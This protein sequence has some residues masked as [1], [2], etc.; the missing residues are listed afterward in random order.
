MT[1][2]LERKLC[3]AEYAVG[4]INSGL[5]LASGGFVGAAHPE[6]LTAELE[7]RF[8]RDGSPRD[9]TLVYA[10][11]QGD[12]KSRG[13]NHLGHP[14]LIK[15]V[16]G[17]HW[18]LA[19]RMG[20]MA[21][22][23]QTQAYNIPQGVICQ[24]FREIGAGRPGVITRVGMGTFI[25]PA[26]Q[27]GRLNDV[28]PDAVV[29]SITLNGEPWL[30]YPSFPVHVG[31]IR[32]SAADPW[33]NLIMDRE[34]VVGDVLQIAQ[35]VKN[36]ASRITG[37]IPNPPSKGLLIAQVQRLL[38]APAPPQAVRVPGVL[39]DHI[40]LAH[41]GEHDQTFAEAYN[42][43]YCEPGPIE[44]V[45]GQSSH[46]PEPMPDDERR[47]IA[48]RAL[49][50]VPTD[51]IANLGIGMP[52]GIA[53][54]AAE[55]GRL[56]RITLTVESGPIGGAP[57]GGLS[58]GASAHPH[59]IVDPATQF[60]FYDGGG[61]DF[62]ALGLAE[63]DSTGSVNVSKFGPRVAG[64]GG[65]VNI[66]QAA[67]RLVFCGTFT[68]GGLKISVHQG[69]LRIDTEGKIRKFVQ[70]VEQVSFSG[71]RAIQLRQPVLYVTE[72]AVFELTAEG[73]QLI[74]VAPG[75]DVQKQVLDL[76]AFAPIVRTVRPMP[77][78]VRGA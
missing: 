42:P 75:I 6:T 74:E 68:A 29:Q 34:A 61:L 72:R 50:E 59:A 10:G 25:D 62:A 51:A 44:L 11:G 67:R 12:G 28:S 58:F 27:G 15:K 21:I 24:L 8:L 53:R 57:A 20:T 60:D 36:S 13:L 63:C 37:N 4:L 66:T 38:D 55:R 3:S 26:H 49:D 52:E 35:A 54:I 31:I 17:G 7:R 9:L 18:A 56:H 14:G 2:P 69:K 32:A 22:Q 5:T 48:A 39:V 16:I 23:G 43:L 64:V 71:P 76:M 73:L 47:I 40:V 30:F 1:T 65:F 33:G 45:T 70:R 77:L 78:H 19:P 46:K 41:E